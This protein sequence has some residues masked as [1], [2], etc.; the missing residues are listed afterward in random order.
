MWSGRADE[1]GVGEGSGSSD[2]DEDQGCGGVGDQGD[3]WWV[4]VSNH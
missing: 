4:V 1:G 3:V 2:D